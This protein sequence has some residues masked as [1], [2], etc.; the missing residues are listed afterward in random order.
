MARA[1]QQEISR[2]LYELRKLVDAAAYSRGASVNSAEVSRVCQSCEQGCSLRWF[3]VESERL[4]A[5]SQQQSI[6]N[7]VMLNYAGY[8]GATDERR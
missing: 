6:S 8:A 7:K 3:Q 2:S 5:G 1:E 4:Q